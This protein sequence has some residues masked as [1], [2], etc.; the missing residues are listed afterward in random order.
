MTFVPLCGKLCFMDVSVK[1]KFAKKFK[2]SGGINSG[3]D[4]N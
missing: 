1:V 2:P 3:K 4:W